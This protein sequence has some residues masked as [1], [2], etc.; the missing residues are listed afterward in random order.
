MLALDIEQF[1]KDDEIAHKENCFTKEA[2]QVALGI[3]M[4][5]EC[6]FAELGEEGDP[7]GYTPPDWEEKKKYIF[8]KYG[9]KPRVFDDIRGLNLNTAGS[10]NNG[11]SLESMRTVMAAIQNY[12]RY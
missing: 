1:W 8:E 10:I 9:K 12:G 3:R 11:S 7:W 2:K 6:V 4:S 5:G